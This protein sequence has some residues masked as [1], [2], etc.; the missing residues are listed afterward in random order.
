[1]CGIVCAMCVSKTSD[2]K[3]SCAPSFCHLRTCEMHKFHDLF[4]IWREKSRAH[5]KE[6]KSNSWTRINVLMRIVWIEHMVY[7][8]SVLCEYIDVFRIPMK[9]D[10]VAHLLFFCLVL[11]KLGISP[12]TQ[13]N[14][15]LLCCGWTCYV[16]YLKRYAFYKIQH[17]QKQKH[18]NQDQQMYMPREIRWRKVLDTL[19]VSPSVHTYMSSASSNVCVVS[20]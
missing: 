19:K 4:L 16:F 8:V 9:R 20:C 3:Y 18:F 10:Y 14:R 12:H 11:E 2:S 7:N 5:P 13:L 6:P 1:M 17:T 15:F